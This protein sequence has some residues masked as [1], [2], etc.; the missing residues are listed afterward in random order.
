MTAARV[1]DVSSLPE[2]D[3]SNRAPLF[4]GQL[5]LCAI[6]GSMFCMLIAIYFYLRL[7]VDVWPPPG[8]Q[9]PHVAAPTLALIPLVLSAFG[10][11]WASE[12]AKKNDRRA[13]LT[14]LLA[15]LILALCF[16][17]F[18]YREIATLNF[19]WA[20]DA[21]GTIVWSILF[22][23]TLDVVADLVMTLVLI[24]AVAWNRYGP[25]QRLG[26]HVDSVVWYFMVAIWIPLYAIIY[27]GPY[28]LGMP[29]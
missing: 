8:T 6:E 25:K 9:L 19:N 28:V 15:N 7:S 2:Y 27:W 11:W 18:R 22:L 4:F 17:G 29:Q 3:I 13:M 12:G 21:H 5:V 23:H 14:G 24:C 20:T 26:V 1:L 10:S 16:L